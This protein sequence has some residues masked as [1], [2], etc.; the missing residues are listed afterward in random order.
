MRLV[1]AALAM[2][3]ML[4][5]R[6][7]RVPTS[8]TKRLSSLSSSPSPNFTPTP[9]LIS[10]LTSS[11]TPQYITAPMVAQSDLAFRTLTRNHGATLT[12]T[13]MLHA[14]NFVSSKSFRDDN[15]DFN[16]KLEGLKYNNPPLIAQ[17]AGDDVKFMTEAAQILADSG[18]DGI[19]INLGCP[20]AI[21]RKGNY[22]AYLLPQTELTTEIVRSIK[23]KLPTTPLTAKIRIQDNIYDTLTIAGKLQEAGVE[24]LTVHGRTLKENKTLTRQ[25][26]WD[27]ISQVVRHLD[28][29]VIANGG[30]EDSRDVHAILETTAAVGC[31]SS[32]ALLENPS[33]YDFQ[34]VLPADCSS[35]VVLDRQV[36][37]CK[38]YIELAK[39]YPPV[40]NGRFGGHSAVKAH[41]FKMLY[42][43]FSSPKFQDLRNNLG[44]KKTHKIEQ[45]EEIVN[46]LESRL[47]MATD[48]DI[49]FPST[50][51]WYRRHRQPLVVKPT[52]NKNAAKEEIN[53]R[54]KA[55]KERRTERMNSLTGA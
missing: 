31:M 20:Q 34:N 21:A 2:M 24:M 41:V 51:S 9:D 23:K 33:L 1:V 36:K 3:M 49:D 29:P 12:Y 48:E 4:S 26:N 45:T 6:G 28:I 14:R 47:N 30:I 7:F 53:V 13:Q 40:G 16:P 44:H 54:L 50:F 46:D 38:E 32:E 10:Y 5:A 43:A 8:P 42:I 19:D 15:Y 35:R 18:V 25:A 17:I 55:L 11:P 27:A 22:G 37:L 39:L 52:I